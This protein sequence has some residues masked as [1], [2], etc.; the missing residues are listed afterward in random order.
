MKIISIIVLITFAILVVAGFSK[1]KDDATISGSKNDT[2]QGVV[3]TMGN[4]A[5]TSSGWKTWKKNATPVYS[6]P[7]HLV[8][9]PSVLHDGSVYRMFYNCFD[10]ERSWGA[11]CQVTSTDGFAWSEVPTKDALSGR[12]IKTR[13]EDRWDTAHETPLVYKYK[14][15]Y[16]LYFT[17]YVHKGDFGTSFPYHIGLA[18]SQDG[19]SFERYGDGPIFSPTEG[20]YDSDAV[21]SPTITE[22]EG[23]LVMLYTGICMKHCPGEAGV[24]LLA[25]TSDDGKVWTKT[26]MPVI[27]KAEI[28]KLFP[29][30]KD[31]AAESDI[32]K[33]PD[34]Y[35]YLFMSL[36]Y[37]NNGHEIGV[38]RSLTPYGPW[39]INPETIIKK[40]EGG[41]DSVGPIAPSVI[42][43]NDKVRMWYHGFGKKSI[44]IG[45]AE[46]SWPLK[47]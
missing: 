40:T 18:I 15:Q 8:G 6:G 14:G 24:T 45:Y 38:A 9:D 12:M 19:V 44:D 17:G 23:K 28:T 32:V 25:A 2:N 35:Y 20:G 43:E 33:G 16:L 3:E 47:I 46:T 30:A 39:D 13:G 22:Y 7:H 36:L 21:F 11:V 5:T 41:F 26:N 34:G 37:G 42:I 27:T 10:P 4:I 31:G 29:E 1:E